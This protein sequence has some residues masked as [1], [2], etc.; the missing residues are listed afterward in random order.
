MKKHQPVFEKFV[1]G[2]V[3]KRE[4]KIVLRLPPYHCELNPTEL[5]WSK[6]KG[7][8]KNR[9]IT[10]KLNDVKQLMIEG[11]ETVTA[12]NWRNF[13]AYV[14]K[15]ERKIWEIDY[16]VDDFFENKITCTFDVGTGD[17]SSGNNDSS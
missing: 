5:S 10:F 2:E 8:V 16:L 15:E 3:A 1:V 13:K 11:V 17:T 9:N 4:N 12:E 6:V 7:Y 14:I